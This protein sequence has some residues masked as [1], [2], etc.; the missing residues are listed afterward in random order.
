NL[1]ITID[2]V[3]SFGATAFNQIPVFNNGNIH[4]QKPA[5]LAKFGATTGFNHDN[6]AVLPCPSGN[7]IYLYIHCDS[8]KFYQ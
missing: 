5:D 4:S 3:G 2:G 8:I 7:T 1:E 6:N